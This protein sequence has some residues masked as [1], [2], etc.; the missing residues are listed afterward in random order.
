MK[1]LHLLN[2]H[3]LILQFFSDASLGGRG[4]TE[5]VTEIGGGWDCMENKCHIN[6][7]EIQAAF[8]CL[9][10]FCKN[11]ARLHELLKLDNTTAVA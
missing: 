9:K 3:L 6:S 4:S 10:V 11:K 2:F 5:Q 7:L 1:L 8:F